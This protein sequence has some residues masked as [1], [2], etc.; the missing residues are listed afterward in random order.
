MKERLCS[1]KIKLCLLRRR[2]LI[3]SGTSTAPC[4]Q[5][6]GG[7]RHSQTGNMTP[8]QVAQTHHIKEPKSVIGQTS[9]NRRPVS[10]VRVCPRGPTCLCNILPNLQMVDVLTFVWMVYPFA[11]DRVLFVILSLE[12]FVVRLNQTPM[13]VL[14][15]SEGTPDLL[16]GVVGCSHFWGPTGERFS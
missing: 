9:L 3:I 12:Y 11:D 6:Q 7:D 4:P 1:L 13:G 5:G 8:R 16:F 10:P 14:W 15:D 2:K